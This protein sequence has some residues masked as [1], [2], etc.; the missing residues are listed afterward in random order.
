MEG[1]EMAVT[2]KNAPSFAILTK[3]GIPDSVQ[4]QAKDY[5]IA[6]VQQSPGTYHVK[7]DGKDIGSVSVKSQAL[8]MLMANMMGPSSKEAL[9]NQFLFLINKAMTTVQAHMEA[10]VPVPE[11]VP[12]PAPTVNNPDSV[13]G[14]A[15]IVDKL[16]AAKAAGLAIKNPEAKDVF[17]SMSPKQI[18][19]K[20][21]IL[22]K[23]AVALYQPVFATS[24]GSVYIT[25]IMVEGLNVA[26]RWKSS[27]LSLR[28]EG[29][30]LG[31]FMMT[32]NDLG[33]GSS[34]GNNGPYASVHFNVG[35]MNGVVKTIGAIA[36]S[37]GVITGK[38]QVGDAAY[39]TGA[40]S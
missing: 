34:S 36:A 25:M 18:M 30:E 5:G 19:A 20:E 11:P 14:S 2:L 35:D 23:D 39:L 4:N 38:G 1:N 15:G 13:V 33:F 8:T 21:P 29:K 31:G 22:L 6:I 10:T 32:L 40:G 12:T 27:K 37:L 16:K 24:G 7:A 28:A 9:K 17:G 3:L 26:A